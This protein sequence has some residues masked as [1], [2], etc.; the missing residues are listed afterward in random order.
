M[1][2]CCIVKATIANLGD[3][4]PCAV[5]IIIAPTEIEAQKIGEQELNPFFPGY[6]YRL[7][8]ENLGQILLPLSLS[9]TIFLCTQNAGRI[10]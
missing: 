7:G 4:F 5:A 1:E 6:P 8:F 3:A 10:R 9:T 2:E